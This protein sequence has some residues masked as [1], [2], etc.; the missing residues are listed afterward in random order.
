MKVKCLLSLFFRHLM[1]QC[2]NCIYIVLRVHKRC[3]LIL[4]AVWVGCFF[5][6]I[7]KGCATGVAIQVLSGLSLARCVSIYIRFKIIRFEALRFKG[8]LDVRLWELN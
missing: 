5:L 3:L 6:Y 4:K 2:A 7:S 8:S 1:P